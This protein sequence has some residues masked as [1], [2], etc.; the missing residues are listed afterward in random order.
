MDGEWNE[1]VTGKGEWEAMGWSRL[2]QGAGSE[3]AL[4]P[5]YTES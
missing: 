3:A 2:V 4:N 5:E 1:A